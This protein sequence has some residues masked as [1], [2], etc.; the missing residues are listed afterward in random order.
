[1]RIRVRGTLLAFALS[2]LS[3]VAL[4]Q[5]P[6]LVVLVAVDQMRGDYISTWEQQLTGGFARFWRDGAFFTN[7]HQDHANTETAPGQASMLSGRFPYSTGI[8]ANNVGVNTPDFRLVESPDTG[9]APFRFQGTTLADWMKARDP[10]TRVLSVSRKDRAAILPVA[11]SHSHT[12]LW[13]SPRTARFTTSTWYSTTLPQWVRDFNAERGVQRLAGRSWDLLLPAT[14]YPEPDSVGNEGRNNF[15]F[16]HVLP[17]DTAR[18]AVAVEG[19]PWMDSLTLALALRGVRNMELGAVATR[20]D[21]LSI[22]L[23]S[24]D[25]IGHRWG[26]DSRELHDQILR[27]DRYLGAFLDSLFALRGRDRVI[28]VLTADHG[29][30]PVP[31]IQSRFGDTRTAVRVPTASFRPVVSAARAALRA[32]GADT[33]ALRWEDLVLW[34]DRNKLGSVP[35]DVAALTRAFA[36]SVRRIPHVARADVISELGAADT[37]RD[38]IARRLSRMFVPG[39]ETHPG[40]LALVAVTLLPFDY[41]GQG[42]TATHGSP[43]DYDT[44]VPVAFLGTPFVRAHIAEK[45]NVVDIA[46]TLAAVL[47][48]VPSERLDGRVLKSALR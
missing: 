28:V 4:G 38:A 22:S 27:A 25:E 24:T 48:L 15:V 1:M 26:P 6:S 12:V 9:A 30:A 37:V 23:S 17:V 11:S 32:A 29:V 10:R 14:A 7:A 39:R 2:A 13:Y 21:L 33:T 36:D 3:G 41:F 35:V 31:G 20:T 46:P 47:G 16:P 19:T 8:V 44:H 45:A 5:R 43:Y 34:I 40:V 18:L 42:N